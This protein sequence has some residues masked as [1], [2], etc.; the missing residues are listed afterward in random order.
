MSNRYGPFVNL[1]LEALDFDVP[2]YPLET[3]Y[4]WMKRKQRN[5]V[6][7]KKFQETAWRLKRQGYFEIVEKQ[8]QKFIKLTSKG[9][10]EKL[11]RKANIIK[12]PKW[13]GKW[14]V[15]IFDIPENSR[16]QRDKFRNLLKVNKFVKLQASVFICP[17]S[18][19]K[20]AIEFLNESGLSDYVRIMRV[21]KM[22]NDKELRKKF[23][24]QF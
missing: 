8:N 3:T 14:R 12:Q 1:F 13:D 15:I 23:H 5:E 21:E 20:E 11:I 19:N 16:P 6:T 17:Y 24:L 2:L 4:E 10:L 7:R 18:F 22:D 9:K